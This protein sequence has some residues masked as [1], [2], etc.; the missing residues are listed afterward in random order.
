[1]WERSH[2]FNKRAVTLSPEQYQFV[3]VQTSR[4]TS[5][6]MLFSK[7]ILKAEWEANAPFRE[8]LAIKRARWKAKREEKERLATERKR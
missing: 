1:L 6:A 7:E 2:A 3:T 4:G 8:A 5:R